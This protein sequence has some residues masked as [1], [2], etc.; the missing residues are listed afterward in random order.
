MQYFKAYINKRQ[1]HNEYHIPVFIK[2]NY[3]TGFAYEGHKSGFMYWEFDYHLTDVSDLEND[4][5][6]SDIVEGK[7]IPLKDDLIKQVF[8]ALE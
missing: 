7:D 5:P 3:V 2:N 1:Y 4:W 6:D 8:E